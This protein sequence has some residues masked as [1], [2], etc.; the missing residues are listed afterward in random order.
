MKNLVL[1]LTGMLLMLY[2]IGV[3]AQGPKERSL[4]CL[5]ELMGE[6]YP[7]LTEKQARIE[8][9]EYR[10]KELGAT[11]L[12]QVQLQLQNS[13]G[14]FAGTNGAFFPTAG[15]FNVNGNSAGKYA[16]ES[17]T[18]NTFGSVLSTGKFLNL[19]NNKR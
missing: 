18:M 6:N 15:V 13:F 2:S 4:S 12:P 16:A 10:K 8:E 19:A 3:H 17:S 14:T 9:A 5:W 11:A 7:M 1:Y